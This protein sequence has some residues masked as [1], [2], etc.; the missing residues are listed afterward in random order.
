MIKKMY[1]KWSL[2]ANSPDSSSS[3]THIDNVLPQ[4]KKKKAGLAFVF[5]L[6]LCFFMVS[7]GHFDK[8][9]VEYN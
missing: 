5:P 4:E 3:T 2:T 9:V 6:S 1:Y 8:R 7:L